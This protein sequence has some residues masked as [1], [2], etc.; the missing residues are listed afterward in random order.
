MS[1]SGL[2]DEQQKGQHRVDT[3]A[4]ARYNILLIAGGWGVELLTCWFVGEYFLMGLL[5]L[6]FGGGAISVLQRNFQEKPSHTILA[7]SIWLFVMTRVIVLSIFGRILY[8]NIV[9]SG[10]AGIF[11]FPLWQ[12]ALPAISLVQV[13]FIVYYAIQHRRAR[14]IA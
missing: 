2:L 9:I 11:K 7:W 8:V 6:L 3:K 1:D 5:S 14:R 10:I 4:L 12:I 13:V